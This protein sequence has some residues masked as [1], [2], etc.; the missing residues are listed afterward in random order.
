MS[1]MQHLISSVHVYAITLLMGLLLVSQLAIGYCKLLPLPH[2]LCSWGLSNQNGAILFGL[3][4][5]SI[6]YSCPH[7][8]DGSFKCEHTL[9]RP[10]IR[11]CGFLSY[12]MFRFC[13]CTILYVFILIFQVFINKLWRIIYSI[14]LLLG[15]GGFYK[16][17]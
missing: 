3:T 6:L 10:F 11:W 9:T 7:I 15:R 14:V 13:P 12:W 17:L 1:G 8:L 4:V 5:M 16:I 2:W